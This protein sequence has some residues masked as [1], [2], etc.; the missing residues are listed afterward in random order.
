MSDRFNKRTSSHKMP[1]SD[2]H[3]QHKQHRGR[4]QHRGTSRNVYSPRD[5]NP[6]PN[7]PEDD[8]PNSVVVIG[9]SLYGI[10]RICISFFAVTKSADIIRVP[11]DGP[12]AKFVEIPV[13]ASSKLLHELIVH[14]LKRDNATTVYDQTIDHNKPISWL[15]ADPKNVIVVI[16]ALTRAL[17][18][19]T[20]MPFEYKTV[21]VTHAREAFTKKLLNVNATS[22]GIILI[23]DWR[24]VGTGRKYQIVT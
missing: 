14:N 20:N 1:T 19:I 24:N 22:T 21:D 3:S 16:K 17:D 10:P 4:S 9:K 13:S 7:T 18:G 15:S 6:L 11:F 2:T 5:S 8:I 12:Y 23:T